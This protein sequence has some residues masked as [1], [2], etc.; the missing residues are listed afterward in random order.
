M[1]IPITPKLA[2]SEPADDDLEIGEFQVAEYIIFLLALDTYERYAEETSGVDDVEDDLIRK[3]LKILRMA[4]TQIDAYREFLEG[5]LSKDSQKM[6]LRRALNL[7]VSNPAAAARRALHFRTLLTR[8]GSQTVKG[9]L[10]NPKYLRQVKAAIAASMLDDSDKALDIFAAIP[11]TNIR[12][13]NWIDVAAKQA[14]SG[15]FAPS[16]V[17]SASNVA[18][19]SNEIT[20]TSIKEAGSEGAAS[21]QV[22]QKSRSVM[23]AEVQDD[24]TKAAQR[25]LEVNNQPDEPPKKSEVVGIATA[26]AIAAM[27][28]PNIPQNIPLALRNLDDE[29]RAAALTGGRVRVAAG[30]GSGKSTTLV[31]RIDYLVKDGRVNP[32]RIMACS[33]NRK[34]ALELKDKIAK[35]VG[36]GSS[37]IQVGTMHSLFAKLIVGTRDTPGFG[38]R[39][40]QDMLRP[41]RLIAPTGKGI[42]SIS[43]SSLSQ[44]IRNMWTECGPDA[45]VSRY[46]Y[47]RSWVEEPPKAKKAGLLLNAWRGN[48]ISLE[49]AKASVTSK[50]E[51]QAVIWYEMYLGLKGDIPGWRPPCNPSK[52]F[53]NFMGRNRKGGERLGDLDDMLKILRDILK[54]DP[55]AKATIQGMYDHICVDEAQDLNL[56]QHQVF[57]MMSEHITQDSKDKSIWMVGDEKQ[58]VLVSTP[59]TKSDGSLVSALD[60][61][62][63]DIVQSYR[64]GSL[65]GQKVRHIAPSDWTWGYEVRTASGG[66]LTMSPNHKIWATEPVLADDRVLVYLMYRNGFGFRV[67]ITNRHDSN[68]NYGKRPVQ[69]RAD[70]LWVLEVHSDRE[71]AL[72]AE[73]SYS[74]AYGVPTQV[75][76]GSERGLN[77]E[78]I[79]SLYSRFGNNGSNLLRDKNLD[80]DLP[81]WFACGVTR[82]VIERRLIHLV[83]HG[84]KGSHVRLEWSGEDLDQILVEAK[85]QFQVG[86]SEGYRRLRKWS[87]NY[88][89]TLVFAR[90]LSTLT[91]I[92]IRERLTVQ[93]D[94]LNLLT[95]SGLLVGMSV[96]VCLEGEL[97][98]DPIVSITQVKG[99]FLD[100]DVEDASNFLGGSV[101]SHNSI[102]QFRGAKP[103]LFE[104]LDE[105][106]G[107]TTRNIRTNYRCQPEIVEA[108]NALIAHDNEGTVVPSMADPRKDRGR[109]S[110][111][112]STPED[113]V[114]AAIDTIGRFRKDID[115]GA[116]AEDYAVL[117]RTNAELND[118]E[119]ACIINEIPYMRRGGKGFLEAPES[120]A[121]LGL[122]DLAAGND[123]SK[124][125]S[126]LVAALMKPDRA[127]F[128]GPDDV[129]KAVDEALNDVARQER[130]DVKSVRPDILL[131]SRYVRMLADKLKL[132]YRLKI[133]SF[134]KGD[135][136]KG[137]W[138]YKQKVDELA[139]NLREMAANVRDLR[140][141]IGENKP[142]TELLDYILDNMKSTVSSWDSTAR[143][144]VTETT[145]LREQITNDVAV[146]SDDD[147]D[148]DEDEAKDSIPPADIGGEGHL[149]TPAKA[150]SV[151]GLG[152]VQ[153]LYALVKPNEND[154]ANVTNPEES[155]GFVQKVARYSKIAGSLRIDP[156]KWEKEQQKLDPEQRKEKPPAISLSTVHCS[157]PDELILT[158]TGWVPICELDPKKHRLASYQKSCNQLFWGHS[159]KRGPRSK[160]T[161]HH[162][163]YDF[164]K[165]CRPYSGDLIRIE[166]DRSTTR[167]TPNHRLLVKLSASFMNKYVVYLMRRG[168]WWRV[169]HCVSATRPYKAGG[170]GGRLGTEKADAGWILGVFATKAEAL[171]AEL[172][173]QGT[174]GIPGAT[175]E[176]Y[177]D[178]KGNRR[179][180]SSDQLHAVHESTRSY[181]SPRALKL[182]RDY[183]L[184]PEYPLY[185]RGLG[186]E[187]KNNYAIAF[188]IRACNLLSGYMELPVVSSDFTLGVVTKKTGTKPCWSVIQTKVEPYQGEVFSLR[189]LPHEYYVSGGAIVHNSVKG[190]QWT[191]VAVLMP[192]G[193]FPMERKPKPDEPPPD[194]IVEKARMKAE[195]NLAYVAITRA[196]VNLEVTCPMNKGVSQFVFDAGLAP[197]ENVPKPGADQQEVIKGASTE[198]WTPAH[199]EEY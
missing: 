108:A 177:S 137:E 42:K 62:V 60:L 101:L 45:L 100:L 150:T 96:P 65:E 171:K 68:Y 103:E 123:Y 124:M 59:I 24:A 134:A 183:G 3:G 159:G 163:G 188:L 92:P 5:H 90:T 93:G 152:A 75:F 191:N 77:Q 39:E 81:H 145:S 114:E 11:M 151:K 119:T 19:A 99:T 78:R 52:P 70:R 86:K 120:K 33:F 132:P 48:D 15:E 156:D 112:V 27:S 25:S 2:I 8:G 57:G 36:E 40:E 51:G 199:I 174:Y 76:A 22:E 105:N 113:N 56:V 49:Q 138:M 79:D 173:I 26:A 84:V 153:F 54:R 64:N 63:G 193:L 176:A 50:A 143:R 167:V 111:Q 9:I 98:L 121:V 7:K 126:S 160:T 139:E 53:E 41:P 187:K 80:F 170:V 71:A 4:D 154:Q 116:Q 110:I 102:Y 185:V 182:L 87:M 58:C 83:A 196:A 190:A 1:L 21:G 141:F 74:L 72:L 175:F 109:A 198:I 95:A 31:A 128:M 161:T 88:R 180:L 35:K 16:P 34:A 89:D 46:G 162:M 69:E 23:L 43:P 10:S 17:D 29:Q 91:G 14:G 184:Y 140:A 32:A 47:P 133:I 67:G 85:I 192:K 168:D 73:E 12:M 55:K 106:A 129:E 148:E 18:A 197:G 28:D 117:A 130:V 189:V 142:T 127:L 115:E 135:T 169:G 146:Y 186:P 181:V 157:P 37:G 61:K 13:R 94:T 155:Q 6:M 122:I 178:T 82:G 125:K 118:F 147:G 166:T 20:A 66:N 104:G 107:W 149:P 97:V 179:L 172:L 131:E 136:R 195:R 158:T 144:M 38:T 165:S 194:P 164:V 44:T 30:A